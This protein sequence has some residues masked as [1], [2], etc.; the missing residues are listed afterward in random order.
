M[1]MIELHIVKVG[2]SRR[3]PTEKLH[4]TTGYTI[5]LVQLWLRAEHD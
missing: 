4:H 1:F 2:G 5:I 3:D